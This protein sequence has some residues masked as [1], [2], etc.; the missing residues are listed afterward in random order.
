MELVLI[1]TLLARREDACLA[2]KFEKRRLAR[3]AGA[4]DED[5]RGQSVGALGISGFWSEIHRDA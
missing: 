5:A 3:V 4:N 1:R 2:Q